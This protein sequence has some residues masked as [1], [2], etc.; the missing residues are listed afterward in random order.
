MLALT[1]SL[2][3]QPPQLRI[4]RLALS[5]H[6]P[7]VT[8]PVVAEHLVVVDHPVVADHLLAVE[9]LVVAEHL[10]AVDH[11]VVADHRLAVEHPVVADHLVAVDRSVAA[12]HLTA[13]PLVAAVSQ[14]QE[15]LPPAANRARV[16]VSA[17]KLNPGSRGLSNSDKPRAVGT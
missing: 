4:V 12:D 9:H 11:P 17:S 8:H 6:P 13:S 1:V 16:V 10:A 15:D 14:V 5:P 2:P 7:V 3:N